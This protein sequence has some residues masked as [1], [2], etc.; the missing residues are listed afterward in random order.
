MTEGSVLERLVRQPL[1]DFTQLSPEQRAGLVRPAI[2]DLH[3]FFDPGAA[4][5][6]RRAPE[7]TLELAR[8]LS[9]AL[10][11][12]PASEAALATLESR[13]VTDGL[14]R[15]EADRDQNVY[16]GRLFTRVLTR[17]VPD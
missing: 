17:A 16:L 1:S 8:G 9:D 3:V 5:E 6:E 7:R 13:L 14:L 11:A 10:R 12:E 2:P 4:L 15:G